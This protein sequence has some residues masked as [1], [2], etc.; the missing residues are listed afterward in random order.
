[1]VSTLPLRICQWGRWAG[2]VVMLRQ[3]YSVHRA[4]STEEA[5]TSPGWVRMVGCRRKKR[6]NMT[7][8]LCFKG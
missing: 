1:M 8:E 2:K 6:E 7:F 3:G 5:G 4:G